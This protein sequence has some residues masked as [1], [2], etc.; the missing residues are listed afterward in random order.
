MEMIFKVANKYISINTIGPVDLK[1]NIA[2]LALGFFSL[3][4]CG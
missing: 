3:S 4:H 2:G 1:T